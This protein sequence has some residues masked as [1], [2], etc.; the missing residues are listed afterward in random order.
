[1]TKTESPE[2]LKISTAAAMTLR[3][4]RGLFYRGAKLGCINLLQVYESG[5]CGSCAYCGLAGSS[6][7]K[8]FIRVDW[9]VFD[10]E[11]LIKRMEG[12]DTIGRICLSM[13]THKQAVPDALVICE[14]LKMRLNLP[15]SILVSP[16]IVTQQDLVSFKK[17]GADHVG[18]AIDA[19]TPQIFDRWRGRGVSG[20]HKWNR[21]W[22]C[23]EDSIEVYGLRR[24]GA[25]LIVGLGE[26]EVEMTRVIQQVFNA[27]GFTH[28]FSF[29][30]EA[31]SKMENYPQCPLEQYRRI[32][33]A[34][35][36]ID[37]DI[38]NIEKFRFNEKNQIIDF[39]IDRNKLEETVL[40]GVPFMT[41]GCPDERGH[42][43]CNR[44]YAN[45]LPGSEIRNFPFKPTRDD[46][47]RIKNQ[48]KISDF[49]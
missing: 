32:Q 40:T 46:I 38:A 28:L 42:V 12:N 36:L 39:G 41:S 18:I 11:T 13:I 10:L 23:L 34:R 15:I 25:H 1:M 6:L 43:A 4:K 22:Q 21:Y 3:L 30:P 33:L 8:R 47:R 45:C 19:A 7:D 35:Y 26:T 2:F 37:S 17:A 44:P 27:G 5:C 14:K 20:P 29:F 9:P 31:G 24:A 49:N 48:L 16:S